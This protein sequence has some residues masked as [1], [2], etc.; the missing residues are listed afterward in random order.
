MVSADETGATSAPTAASPRRV[1]PTPAPAASSP[2]LPP[3]PSLDMAMVGAAPLASVPV[4]LD[5]GGK[6]AKPIK[7]SSSWA[8]IASQL[9]Q[10]NSSCALD[11][12]GSSP[13]QERN[14][15]ATVVAFNSMNVPL[16]PVTEGAL[17]FAPA[18]APAAA[19]AV[20]PA[21]AEA[22]AE[23]AAEEAAALELG[24][25]IGRTASGEDLH[26]APAGMLEM[27]V[28]IERTLVGRDGA[29]RRDD[30]RD[31]L[32]SAAS[33]DSSKMRVRAA[34]SSSLRAARSSSPRCSR[35]WGRRW[36][37]RPPGV[38][39]PGREHMAPRGTRKTPEQT[40]R[41]AAA[42]RLAQQQRLA[43]RP[44]PPP[45]PRRGAA[46]G[47]PPPPSPSPPPAPSRARSTC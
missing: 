2:S 31:T 12:I 4:L 32:G 19:A 29:G 47:P 37:A 7:E 20:S 27:E 35:G 34:A 40:R 24:A 30:Q 1:S 43:R 3:R 39:P 44:A 28:E 46:A 26:R 6:D 25:V 11:G 10:S 15:D 17:A 22:A 13:S 33:S 9:P 41:D 21:M 38:L 14:L 36:G 5:D 8:E 45:A 18:P 42:G 23:A 16:S